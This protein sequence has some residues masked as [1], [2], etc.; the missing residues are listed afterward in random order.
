MST[1]ETTGLTTTELR[2]LARSVL[3]DGALWK[4]HVRATPERRH[5]ELLRIDED[6]MIWLISWMD[7]H[8]TGFHDHDVSAGAVAV[9]QGSVRE[10]RLRVGAAPAARV[11]GAGEVLSFEGSDIHRVT[12]MSGEPAV[13]VHVYSPPLQRTGAYVFDPGGALRRHSQ[14]AE[15]ELR[16]LPVYG[17]FR[18]VG[19]SPS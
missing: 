14:P 15:H 6:V 10:E 16:P 9:A 17:T 18:S 12:H 13:T 11:Y 3:A 8:D 7:G 1:T 2:A 5:Y 19:G 4:P